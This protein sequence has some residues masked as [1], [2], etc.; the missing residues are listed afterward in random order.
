MSRVFD[1]LV[2]GETPAP[3]APTW[4]KVVGT[5]VVIEIYRSGVRASDGMPIA[6]GK[7]LNTTNKATAYTIFA[8]NSLPQ[9]LSEQLKET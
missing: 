2:A 1:A 8:R 3:S 5:G 6:E 9:K 4:K 7:V